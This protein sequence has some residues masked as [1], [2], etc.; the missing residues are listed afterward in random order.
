VSIDGVHVGETPLTLDLAPGE[1]KVVLTHRD[2]QPVHRVVRIVGGQVVRVPVDLTREG[3][4][5]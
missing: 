1:H 5:R 2:Y 4:K 3:V